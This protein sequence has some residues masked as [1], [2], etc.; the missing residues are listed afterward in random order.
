MLDDLA[1]A[2]QGS[3]ALRGQTAALIQSFDATEQCKEVTCLYNHVNW[4][5]EDLIEHPEKLAEVR[6]VPG[7]EPDY[8]L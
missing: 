3:D 2:A 6:T 8:F 1:S 4:W 7:M 5:L